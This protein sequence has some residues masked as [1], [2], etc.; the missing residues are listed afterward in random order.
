MVKSGRNLNM[1]C[2]ISKRLMVAFSGVGTLLI[3]IWIIKYSSHGFDFTDDSFYLVWMSNPYSY[4]F[5]IT[6]FGFVYHPLYLLLDGNIAALRQVNIL[7]TFGLAW[8]LTYLFITSLTP[9]VSEKRVS[10]HLVAAGLA[11]SSLVLFDSWLYTPSYNSLSLQA[12]LI[13]AIGLLQAD[14]A[15][16]YKSVA[17]WIVIGIGGWLAFMAKPSTAVA[18]AVCVLICLVTSRK[19]SLHLLFLAMVTAIVLLLSSA[20]LI[21]GSISGFIERLKVGLE[22]SSYLQSGNTFNEIL[23][24]DTFQLNDK[25]KHAILV[26][27]IASLLAFWGAWSKKTIGLFITLSI[28]L[29]FFVYI[30]LLTID[31][32][33]GISGLGRYKGLLLFGVVFSAVL[34][35]LIFGRIKAL[36]KTTKSQW[37]VACLFITMPHIYAFGTGSNYWLV[38]SSAGVF[39]LLAGLTLLGPTIRERASWLIALPLVL[40]TQAVTATLLKTGLEQ[41]YRQPE[42]LRN[43]NATL[44]IGLHRSPLILSADY[45]AYIENAITSAQNS[46]FESDSPVIDLSG[47]SPGV[48]YVLGANSIG[49]AWTI[50][51]YSGS[52]KLAEAALSLTPCEKIA[53]AWILYEPNGPR[54]IPTELMS[55]LGSSFPEGYE[56]VGAWQTAEGAGGYT[57]SRIQE[58]YKPIAPNKTLRE[59]QSLREK[60]VK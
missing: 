17:G 46:G 57:V 26:T 5:S 45:A 35:G 60:E 21:D 40:A 54:S 53:T 1:Y 44:E 38:G 19:F 33:H 55:S 36:K 3:I 20:I 34:A 37:S 43:N 50:G 14:K 23:R 13:T 31:E 51:G 8:G 48:L 11:T 4:D 42:P 22:F 52:L 58:F 24:I 15:G 18:L 16:T 12:L 56:Q 49:Q 25:I 39:W 32:F 41:P 2:E 47:Q 9:N 27:V 6:Q 10:L 7:I 28:S 59:C 30:V 29:S